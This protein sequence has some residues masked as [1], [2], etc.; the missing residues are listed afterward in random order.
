MDGFATLALNNVIN[1]NAGTSLTLNEFFMQM[2]TMVC[3]CMHA[4][5]HV[6]VSETKGVV[7]AHVTMSVFDSASARPKHYTLRP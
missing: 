2:Q 1:I 4:C 5:E 6:S 3:M 7:R